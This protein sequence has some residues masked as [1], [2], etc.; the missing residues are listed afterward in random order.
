MSP[1]EAPFGSYWIKDAC[2]DSAPLCSDVADCFRDT[3]AL[4]T[5][6]LLRDS[7]VV[8]REVWYPY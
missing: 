1:F 3:G 6:K 7:G 4:S 5:S 8:V 2:V